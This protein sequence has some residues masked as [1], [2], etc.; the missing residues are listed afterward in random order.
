MSRRTL[1]TMVAAAIGLASAIVPVVVAQPAAAA[2]T[3]VCNS[4]ALTM[5]VTST[6]PGTSEFWQQ[7]HNEP[8]TGAN[9]WQTRRHNVSNG[10]HIGRTLPAADGVVYLLVNDAEGTLRRYRWNGNAWDDFGGLPYRVVGTGF[11]RYNQPEHRNKI[12]VDE[13]GRLYD[14]D[15]DGRLRVR[16]WQGD[17]ASGNW[18][19]DTKDGKNIYNFTLGY[20]S[21]LITAAGDGVIYARGTDGSLNRYRWSP[22]AQRIINSTS[23]GTGWNVY[24]RIFSPGGD[25]LYAVNADGT[26]I[27]YRWME[28][29]GHWTA[30]AGTTA[31]TRG[32]SGHI[33]YGANTNSCVLTGY[34][35]VQR[36]S[37]PRRE[38]APNS[39]IE[40]PDGKLS[41]FYV[42]SA[43][44]LTVA[45]QIN[46]GQLSPL[47]YQTFPEYHQ[48]TGQPG[49]ALHSDGKLEVLAN[50]HSDG[51]YRGK[52]QQIANGV[53]GGNNLF[54]KG[55][56][57]LSDPALVKAD[58]GAVRKFAVDAQGQMWQQSNEEWFRRSASKLATADFSVFDGKSIVGRYADNSVYVTSPERHAEGPPV[59]VII[60]PVPSIA[61]DIVGKPSAVRHPN[62]DVQIFAQRSDGKIYT[63]RGRFGLVGPPPVWEPVS[64]FVAGGSPVALLLDDTLVQI[65][66]RGTDNLVY[67]SSQVAPAAGFGP[68]RVPVVEETVTDPTGTVKADKKPVFSWRTPQGTI[69]AM[70]VGPAGQFTG[71]V[72]HRN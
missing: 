62:G 20:R 24:D 58:N 60:F 65:A 48:F 38:N 37:V 66:V 68:W 72:G 40:G 55:G 43:G 33:D 12:T 14:L 54:S 1:R 32:F 52:T 31:S 39:V 13:K 42:N 53:W 3:L 45:K 25:L 63:T 35:V 15:A 6:G 9:S 46:A 23:V 44:G 59:V 71:G 18:T 16:I 17:H 5:G 47:E 30:P 64:D 26:I 19:P 22:Q 50:S 69:A 8:E 70:Q 29:E 61:A 11:S 34:P 10:W 49:V 4:A 36:P 2:S 51:E 56:L 27:W 57:M 67:V 28:D 7:A 21:N 41:F